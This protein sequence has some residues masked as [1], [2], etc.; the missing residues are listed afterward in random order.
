MPPRRSQN[1]SCLWFAFFWGGVLA[2][3]LVVIELFSPI[4]IVEKLQ[5]KW[6]LLGQKTQERLH[7]KHP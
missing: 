4:S 1:P 7:K 6:A 3:V 2:L 5:Q